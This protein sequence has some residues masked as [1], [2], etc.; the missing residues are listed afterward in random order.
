VIISLN[1]NVPEPLLSAP[2]TT[3]VGATEYPR[4]AFVI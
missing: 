1:A 4:P 3:M 2:A